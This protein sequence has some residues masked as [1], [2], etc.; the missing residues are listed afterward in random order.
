MWWQNNM[1]EMLLSSHG[2]YALFKIHWLIISA[3]V[4]LLYIKYII[5]SPLYSVTKAQQTYFF[6]AFGFFLLLKITPIVII[7]ADYFFNIYTLQ[8]S[9]LFFLF[10]P[11][12]LFILQINFL[13][14]SLCLHQAKYILK[15]LAHPWISLITFNGLIS[16]YYIPTVFNVVHNNILLSGLAQLILFINAFFM[17]WVIIN[18]IPEIKGLNYLMRA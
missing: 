6:I 17:W 11:F 3:I 5:R 12:L 4:A 8:L 16:I 1:L 15:I 18:P 14:Q 7:G 9:F 2:W 13:R 10:V